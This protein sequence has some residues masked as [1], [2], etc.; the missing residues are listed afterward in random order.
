MSQVSTHLVWVS[1]GFAADEQD[2]PC[3][4]FLQV[5]A[6]ALSKQYPNLRISIVALQ[7]PARREPYQW[8]GHTV[9]PCGG[10][11]K[12]GVGRWL[13]WRR[14]MKRIQALHEEEPIHC[15]HAM[16][17]SEAWYIVEK[18]A[19]KLDVPAIVSALG[20]DVLSDN[21]YLRLVQGRKARMVFNSQLQVEAWQ[22]HQSSVPHAVIPIGIEASAFP[23]PP[24]ELGSI[25]VIGVGWF[26]TV[27]AYDHFLTVIAEARQ[28]RPDLKV[29]LVGGGEHEASLKAQAKALNL[30][31]TVKFTGL[32]PREEVLPLMQQAKVL[33]HT[34]QYESFGLVFAEALFVGLNVVSGPVGVAVNGAHWSVVEDGSWAATL[35]QM[36]DKWEPGYSENR[37]PV[38]EMVDAYATLYAL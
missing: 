14:A 6:H 1:P 15:L 30:E 38:S 27:K 33:L 12:G 32:L 3:L 20:Q 21:K 29:V 4:P 28:S 10:N 24:K 18:M 2:T 25:D 8:F 26:S 5:F 17:L 31:E 36:L 16:W 19:D 23:D 37:Y 35:L 22:K 34:S 13:T 9:Y 7:Y 11:N